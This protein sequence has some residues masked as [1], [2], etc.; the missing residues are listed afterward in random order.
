M[1]HVADHVFKM[2]IAQFFAQMK[3]NVTDVYTRSMRPTQEIYY[4]KL[5]Y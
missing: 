4:L 5:T 3:R 2:L 1:S